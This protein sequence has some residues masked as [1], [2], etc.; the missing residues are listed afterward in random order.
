[1]VTIRKLFINFEKNS[2][3]NIKNINFYF[4]KFDKKYKNVKFL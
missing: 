3:Y 4:K 2:A 1:M